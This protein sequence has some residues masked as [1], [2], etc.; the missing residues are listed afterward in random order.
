[1]LTNIDLELPGIIRLARRCVP[2]EDGS[3]GTDELLDAVPHDEITLTV[4]SGY[5]S[6]HKDELRLDLSAWHVESPA[7]DDAYHITLQIRLSRAEAAAIRDYLSFLLQQ[8][9]PT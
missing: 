8:K 3:L 1:M 7:G 2:R 9:A 5:A 6:E 4:S